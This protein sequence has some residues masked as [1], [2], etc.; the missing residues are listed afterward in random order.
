LLDTDGARD[1]RSDGSDKEDNEDKEEDSFARGSFDIELGSVVGWEGGSGGGG[2]GGR[3]GAG[4][5]GAGA[6]VLQLV[7]QTVSR[8]TMGSG[9]G[10]GVMRGMHDSKLLYTPW[11]ETG[12]DEGISEKQ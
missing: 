6:G 12:A 2:G 10:K 4:D 1:E 8:I 11:C 7:Q 9:T 5:E 3:A